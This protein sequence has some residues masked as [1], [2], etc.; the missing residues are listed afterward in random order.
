MK[1][2][3]MLR[4]GGVRDRDDDLRKG[5]E[6]DVDRAQKLRLPFDEKDRELKGELEAVNRRE[7]GEDDDAYDGRR[8]CLPSDDGPTRRRTGDKLLADF[9]WN[10]EF[11]TFRCL[12]SLSLSNIIRPPKGVAAPLLSLLLIDFFSPENLEPRS[13]NL[14]FM[15][16]FLSSFP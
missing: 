15:E 2:G 14:D 1:G 8:R 10:N 6:G 9:R 11:P 12:L 7:L 13:L 5:R 16:F 4:G 3:E